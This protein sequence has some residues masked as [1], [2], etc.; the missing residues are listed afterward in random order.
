MAEQQKTMNWQEEEKKLGESGGASLNKAMKVDVPYAV[1]FLDE[2]SPFSDTYEGVTR[3]KVVFRV[4]VTGGGMVGEELSW[5]TTKT[6]RRDSLYGM[7][8][9]L[10]AKAGKAMGMTVNCVASGSNKDRRYQLKEYND[11][12]FA[13]KV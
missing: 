4:R 6:R 9:T 1:T 3:D 2:G 10:F 5:F 13:K 8:T 12:I 11:L 7:L